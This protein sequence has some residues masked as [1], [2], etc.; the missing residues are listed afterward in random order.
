MKSNKIKSWLKRLFQKIEHFWFMKIKR[1]SI[2]YS[3]YLGVKL[4]LDCQIL[5]DPETTF[6][7]EPWL[8]KLGNH[9]DITSGVKFVTHE[10]G[11]WVARGIDSKYK[12]LDTF[13]PIIVGNN[14]IIGLDSIIMP[15]V[16]IGN[17]VIIAAKSVV[18]KDIPDNTVVAGVPAKTISTI[19]KFFEKFTK[20][21]FYPTKMMTASEKKVYLQKVHPEWFD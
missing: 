1:D 12:E 19:E 15:G 20:R 16:K 5:A 14:V 2:A 9:V 3:K 6:G 4:G 21:Q 8:I 7:T 10:G 11:I 17:N 18:T 13:Q